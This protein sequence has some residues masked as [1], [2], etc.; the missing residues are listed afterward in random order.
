MGKWH[1][2]A[3]LRPSR[4]LNGVERT[5]CGRDVEPVDTEWDSEESP[6]NVV[7][8]CI[9]CARIAARMEQSATSDADRAT[10]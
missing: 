1:R 5:L 6:E 7:Y 2:T 9:R 4:R 10:V 3:N 8:D